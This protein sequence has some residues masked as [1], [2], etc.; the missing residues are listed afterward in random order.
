MQDTMRSMQ[1]HPTAPTTPATPAVPAAPNAPA[2][3]ATGRLMEKFLKIQPLTFA[4]ISK[5]SL[6]PVK[7]IKEMEKAFEFLGCNEEQKISCARYKLQQEVEAWWQITKPI[8]AAAH[9]VLTWEIFKEAF[10]GNYFPTS[11]RKKKEIELMELVQGPRSMLK[12]QQKFEELFFFT[13]P[14]LNTDEAKAQKFKDGLRP[15]LATVMITYKAQGYL[16]VVQMAKRI[17]DKQRDTYLTNMGSSKR[18]VPFADKEYSKFPQPVYYSSASSQLQ[19]GAIE[20]SAPKPVYANPN[21]KA[22]EVPTS[23]ASQEAK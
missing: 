3:D 8:L 1:T 13:P 22:I 12:Y 18:S 2:N 5:D 10:F 4:G 15:F 7:W 20:S 16:E 11:V 9:S 19:K 6:L 23:V 17:E 14:H 21:I